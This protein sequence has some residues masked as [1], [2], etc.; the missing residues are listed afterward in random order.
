MLEVTGGH[1]E[2]VSKIP[3]ETF[4]EKFISINP[5]PPANLGVVSL[6]ALSGFICKT[7]SAHSS[8]SC[9][10]SIKT[11]SKTAIFA[12]F[13]HTAPTGLLFKMKLV[14]LGNK[15][16][17][18][19]SSL[20]LKLLCNGELVKAPGY[21]EFFFWGGGGLVHTRVHTWGKEGRERVYD[22]I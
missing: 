16:N 12:R 7:L 1:I 9:S 11:P 21:C 4:N 19:S 6:Q 5:P 14:L 8:C 15:A 18:H 2:G 3:G 20:C 22:A 13:L 10:S 17:S